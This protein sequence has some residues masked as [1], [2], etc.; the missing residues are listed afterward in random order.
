MAVRVRVRLRSDSREVATSVL[1]NTGFETDTPDVALPLTLAKAL[2]LW[3]PRGGELISLETGGGDAEAYFIENALELMLDLGD[4]LLEPVRVN[5]IVN[6]NIS[7]VLLSDYVASIL[8][9]VILDA[10][11]GL[12]RLGSEDRV[13]TSVE[14]SHWL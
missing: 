10:K 6:P 4:R 5:A 1:V 12:W 7:E 3:P 9:I 13:R 8:N 11:R 14:P 2:G